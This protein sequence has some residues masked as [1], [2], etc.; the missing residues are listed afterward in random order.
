[1]N[2]TIRLLTADDAAALDEFLAPHTAEAFYLRSNAKAAGLVY[3]GKPLQA[4][5]FGAFENGKL[6][7]ALAYSWLNT[8]LVYTENQACLHALAQAVLPSIRKRGGKIDALLGLAPHV[9]GLIAGLRLPQEA[10]RRFGHDGLFLLDLQTLRLPAKA[11]D[12]SLRLAKE[13]DRAL[14][15]DWRMAFNIEA[16]NAQP[17]PALKKNVEKEVDHWLKT[18]QTFILENG[19]DPVSFCG[20]G[21]S[22][23]EIV[24][25]GP[26]WTPVKL[27]NRSYGRL[28]TGY[29]LRQLAEERPLLREA[30]LFASRPEAI[31][32]YEALGFKRIA[33]WRLALVKEDYRL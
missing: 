30:T 21:G 8:L 6:V 11:D 16:N 7:G 4:E 13:T 2:F 24:I 18:K 20:I 1:M 3:E 26:V 33:D 28:V 17:G 32:V 10:F 25:V 23:P 27:R 29:G 14:L 22:L 12:L 31:R 5:Y 15:I 9:D 19:S